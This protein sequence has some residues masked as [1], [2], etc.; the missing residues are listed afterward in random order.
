MKN[1]VSKLFV[2]AILASSS[3]VNAGL[4]IGGDL[5]DQT[6]ADFLEGQ[7]GSGDLDFFNISNLDSGASSLTWHTD[8]SG[9]TNVLSI[10]D[11]TYNG[12]NYLIGGYSAVGH[13]AVGYRGGASTS[14]N[15]VFNLSLSLIHTPHGTRFSSNQRD[16]RDTSDLFATF[17]ADLFGGVGIVEEGWVYGDANHLGGASYGGSGVSI[18]DG[19]APGFKRFDINGIE[20]YTWS[21]AQPLNANVPEPSI[22]ALFGLGLV[23]LGFARRRQS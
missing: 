13:D 14:S 5:L 15:F 22:I 11:V 8:V 6:G 7:L 17:G 4:I 16:Q 1:L 21:V 2:A 9:K 12:T 3:V 10:Y 19:T 20:S 18:L 23:G